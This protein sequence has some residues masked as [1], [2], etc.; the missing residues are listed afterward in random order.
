[1][2]Q[3][4]GT[5]ALRRRRTARAAVSPYAVVRP[6]VG[7]PRP[8][9]HDAPHTETVHAPRH[10]PDDV[11]QTETPGDA[12]LA[13]AVRAAAPLAALLVWLLAPWDR[14]RLRL[15]CRALADAVPARSCALS[16][17]AMVRAGGAELLRY[18][19]GD[20]R[21]RGIHALIAAEADVADALR[22]ME[23]CGLEAEKIGAM[24]TGHRAIAQPWSVVDPTVSVLRAALAQGSVDVWHFAG[25]RSTRRSVFY[26]AVLLVDAI[27]GGLAS[28]AAEYAA[29]LVTATA[30]LPAGSCP[31]AEPLLCD[32]IRAA[33]RHRMP[34]V[35][36]TF[37]RLDGRFPRA[38]RKATTALFRMGQGVLVGPCDWAALFGP[39]LLRKAVMA[40][41]AALADAT[42][43]GR[44]VLAGVRQRVL[45]WAARARRDAGAMLGWA[46]AAFAFGADELRTQGPALARAA[47]GTDGVDAL[48]WLVEHAGYVP[49]AAVVRKACKDDAAACIGYLMDRGLVDT[50]VR[51]MLGESRRVTALVLARTR[52]PLAVD[53]YKALMVS[54]EYRRSPA[55][56]ARTASLMRR[57]ALPPAPGMRFLSMCLDAMHDETSLG[58]LAASGYRIDADLCT[59]LASVRPHCAGR[60]W[61]PL[62]TRLHTRW[63]KMCR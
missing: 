10:K 45:V 48:R 50:P 61:R 32:T 63:H 21:P 58:M 59:W 55:C 3:E 13:V 30:N 2:Q 56:T 40:G 17:S 47:V 54:D 8:R 36:A 37:L 12:A 53:S 9:S 7:A 22:W 60:R 16:L 31:Y 4:R 62:A 38:R 5:H 42:L 35:A 39:S 49:G 24:L 27:R 1:M 25:G 46:T 28:V 51:A 43:R 41:D 6:A 11:P 57:H 15:T 33:S 26:A 52:G 23:R 29:D 18:G 19:A 44:A 14:A 20:A 34:A